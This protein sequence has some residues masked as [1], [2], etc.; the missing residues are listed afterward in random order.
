MAESPLSVVVLAAGEGKRMRSK[1]PKVLH[2]VAGKP[3]LAHV[4]SAAK[5]LSL[6]RFMWSTDIAVRPFKPRS[7]MKP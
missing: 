7:P 1:H 4:L 6:R 5:A 2:T 3:M